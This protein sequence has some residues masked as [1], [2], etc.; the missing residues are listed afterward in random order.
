L[1]RRCATTLDD[2]IVKLVTPT[3]LYYITVVK[4]FKFEL[5]KIG[6]W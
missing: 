2:T 1:R 5:L 4:T 3:P 6:E